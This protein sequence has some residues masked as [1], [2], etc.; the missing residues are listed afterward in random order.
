MPS[1]GTQ[2]AKRTDARRHLVT[3]IAPI[4]ISLGLALAF[5]GPGLAVATLASIVWLAWRLDNAAGSF[6]VLAVL[7]LIALAVP[8]MLL[9]LMAVTH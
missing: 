3:W 8:A 9:V 5:A 4:P 2:Q 1:V 6:F 7:L